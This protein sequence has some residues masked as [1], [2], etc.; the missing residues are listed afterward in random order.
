M[1]NRLAPV[2]VGCIA[3]LVIM[4][5]P[6]ASGSSSAAE[7][8]ITTASFRSATLKED[9][10]YNVYLRPDTRVP[11]SGIRCSISCTAAATR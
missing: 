7:G 5:A 9:L 6:S 11:A 8:S 2:V 3:L 10:N 1:G 4:L